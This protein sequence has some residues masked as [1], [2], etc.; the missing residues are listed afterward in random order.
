MDTNDYWLLDSV[1]EQKHALSLLGMESVEAIFDRPCHGMQRGMLIEK[2]A[3]LFGQGLLV[4]SSEER[5]EFTPSADEIAQALDGTLDFDY[6]L[7]A[8]GGAA[9]EAVSKPD[10]NRFVD[11]V[12]G[13]DS[14]DEIDSQ[15]RERA[16]AFCCADKAHLEKFMET[17]HLRGIVPHVPSIKWDEVSPW[18]ALYWK[19]L[20]HAHRARFIGVHG[21]HVPEEHMIEEYRGLLNW[22]QSHEGLMLPGQ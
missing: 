22:H 19:Q 14:E 6:G 12:F 21:P 4:A 8:A 18:Q 20:P 2:L 17:I 13:E 3:L 16:G 1:L 11:G 7:T 10:W 9:W 15:R 5:G